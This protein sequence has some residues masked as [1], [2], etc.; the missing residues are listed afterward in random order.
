MF[1][2]LK[3]DKYCGID[4]VNVK[5]IELDDY[6]V[7]QV[8]EKGNTP[9]YY[10]A[11]YCEDI[12]VFERLI[13][14]GA[15]IHEKPV[16]DSIAKDI[17]LVKLFLK[18]KAKFSLSI[19]ERYCPYKSFELLIDSGVADNA[20]PEELDT[21]FYSYVYENQNIFFGTSR[22]NDEDFYMYAEKLRSM[23]A[24]LNNPSP[25]MFFELSGWIS[26]GEHI[27][28]FDNRDKMIFQ[29]LEWGAS[30]DV[31]NHEG[32]SPFNIAA[33]YCDAHVVEKYLEHG[34]R[35]DDNCALISAVS[36]GNVEVVE[37]LLKAGA[38]PNILTGP[39][40]NE[41]KPRANILISL[42]VSDMFDLNSDISL[43]A[44]HVACSIISY[45]DLHD[46]Y[47]Q[48]KIVRMLIK[49]GADVNAIT[50]KDRFLQDMA[51]YTPLDY[52]LKSLGEFP[53]RIVTKKKASSFEMK[54]DLEY[55]N[56]LDNFTEIVKIL[57]DEGAKYHETTNVSK[58]ILKDYKD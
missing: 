24:K 26:E 9:L 32:L 18:H 12:W 58:R 44:L 51:Q 45:L 56:S 6:Y 19:L 37:L 57:K 47:A 25:L 31:R 11:L 42:G 34:A 29:L 20:T 36:T 14:L 40:E 23:G 16:P 50:D 3:R 48:P 5:P 30:T 54:Y 53:W 27:S 35:P 55:N 38:D 4:W 17:E 33:F 21:I 39:L 41:K 7:H 28:R 49:Y 43:S 2:F 10:A 1:E 52:A 13:D 22:L 8:D 46:K 15:D